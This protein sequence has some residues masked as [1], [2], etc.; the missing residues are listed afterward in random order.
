MAR[1]SLIG[2]WISIAILLTINVA[3]AVNVEVDF[4][5]S[6]D[7]SQFSSIAWEEGTPA[8]DP[9]IERK[10][11]AAI[12]RE[13]IPNGFKEVRENPD[14]LLITHA[15]LDMGKQIDVGS[16]DY[17]PEYPGWKKSLAVTEESYD[18]QMGVLIVDILDA[19]NHQLIWR[20]IATGN[21]AKKPERRDEK[22]DRTM[23][24][25]FRGFPPKFKPPK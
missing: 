24:K 3:G 17:W 1:W 13:L 18:S 6:V 9:V 15:S 11:H 10:I 19:A 21:V 16:F 25:M 23:A 14:L 4:D 2:G 8:M 7:F 22:L 5:P 12:E 20:G